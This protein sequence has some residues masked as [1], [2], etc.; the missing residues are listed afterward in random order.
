M[1]KLI[2]MTLLST[3]LAFIGLWGCNDSDLIPEVSISE[4]SIIDGDTIKNQIPPGLAKRIID[5]PTNTNAVIVGD[6]I[7]IYK[8]TFEKLAKPSPKVNALSKKGANKVNYVAL[9]GSLSSGVRD[10]GYFNEGMLTSFPSLLANQ[11]G[12]S[13]FSLPLFDKSEFNGFGKKEKT[14]ENFSGGPVPKMKYVKNNIASFQFV[15]GNYKF[16]SLE[17]N[18]NL[19]CIA[20]PY[21]LYNNLDLNKSINSGGLGE[22]M[23]KGKSTR[24]LGYNLSNRLGDDRAIGVW[25]KEKDVDLFT[26]EYGWYEYL[27]NPSEDPGLLVSRLSELKAIKNLSNQKPFAWELYYKHGLLLEQMRENGVKYGFLLNIPFYDDIPLH[28]KYTADQLYKI[29]GSTP[30][31]VDGYPYYDRQDWTF[32]PSGA[33]DSLFSPKVNIALKKGLSSENSLHGFHINGKS[34]IERKNGSIQRINE[35]MK[36]LCDFYG[37]TV[38]DL[39]SIYSRIKR[40]EYVTHDG[41]RIDGRWPEGNFF[42]ED[43]I[44]P[45][46]L[47]QAVITNEIINELNKSAGTSIPLISITQFN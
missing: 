33:I 10:G 24:T 42:S 31:Y 26:L 37:Y 32:E 35:E 44:Y 28:Y 21:F 16:P 39:N 46:A 40:G 11:L 36:F 47:G 25:L 1:K 30:L 17:K 5:D 41:V 19:D 18:K 3:A 45:T 29:I 34:E 20:S 13:D 9:G 2:N 7:V 27:E 43:G 4:Y 38:I 22:E 15:D 8:G 23:V 6:T 14:N 12:I